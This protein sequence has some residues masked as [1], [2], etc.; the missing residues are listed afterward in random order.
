MDSS[1]KGK[2]KREHKGSSDEGRGSGSGMGSDDDDDDNTETKKPNKKKRAGSK[3]GTAGRFEYH[4]DDEDGDSSWKSKGREGRYY[5][6]LVIYA[7][8]VSANI[9]LFVLGI[10][11]VAQVDDVTRDSKWMSENTL[12]SITVAA[13]AVSVAYFCYLLTFDIQWHKARKAKTLANWPRTKQ[14]SSFVAIGAVPYII[15]MGYVIDLNGNDGK[16]TEEQFNMRYNNVSAWLA[17]GATCMLIETVARLFIA[18]FGQ[19]VR[20]CFKGSASAYK[21]TQPTARTRPKA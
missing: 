10:G 14:Q 16:V 15:A 18:L 8:W 19:C 5:G 9:A 2:P 4:S 1:R 13:A 17:I 3:R 12:F 11:Q 6:M 20:C 7:L 21:S